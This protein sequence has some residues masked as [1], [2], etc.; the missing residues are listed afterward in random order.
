[1]IEVN[2]FMSKE[3]IDL[4]IDFHKKN[5]NLKNNFSKKHRQTEIIMCH[6]IHDVSTIIKIKDKLNKFIKNINKNYIINYF[7]IVKW[8]TNEF[9]PEHLDFNY[10]PYTSILYLNEDFEGGETVVGDK[11]IIP[12]KNKLIAFEG[13]KIIHKVNEI[14]KGIR[15]TIPCWYKYESY[16]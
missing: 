16:S 14:K 13:N 15:Y 9:Q 10:H 1:M 6:K 2:N 3:D 12:K 7:E 4:F 11:I 5:F 8:P